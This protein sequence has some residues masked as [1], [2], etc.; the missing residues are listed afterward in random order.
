MANSS[1]GF[2]T[3]EVLIAF[4]ILSASIAVS[5]ASY[6]QGLNGLQSAQT[7]MAAMSLLA[8]LEYEGLGV[9][10]QKNFSRN[11]F[12]LDARLESIDI[13]SFSGIAPKRLILRVYS[14]DGNQIPL[15]EVDTIVVPPEIRQ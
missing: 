7:R 6:T 8:E 14:K 13:K 3:L 11:G 1:S 15:V 5:T 10:E 12:R 4:V 2:S 9:V